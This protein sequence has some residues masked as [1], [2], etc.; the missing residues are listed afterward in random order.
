[1]L[2]SSTT[3]HFFLVLAAACNAVTSA[4]ESKVELPENH[5][6]ALRA[7]NLPMT[8]AL[9]PV[10]SLVDAPSRML[11]LATGTGPLHHPLKSFV[12]EHPDRPWAAEDQAKLAVQSGAGIVFDHPAAHIYF[13]DVC[14]YAAVTG[15]E[16]IDYILDD[17]DT[18]QEIYTG[19]CNTMTPTSTTGSSTTRVSLSEL[20]TDAMAKTAMPMADEMG[21]TLNPIT[22]GTYRATSITVA[23]D[24]TVT[25]QGGHSDI[26][27]FQ[28]GSTMIT[29]A[30]TKF[31]LL[32]PDGNTPT[33]DDPGPEPANILFAVHAAATTGA[34]SNI[35]GSIL[36]GAAITL[37]AESKATGI[38]LATAGATFGVASSVNEADIIDP[39]ATVSPVKTLIDA[40]Q[41]FDGAKFIAGESDYWNDQ[42]STNKVCV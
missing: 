16:A 3:S 37:G 12:A 24:T 26:F 13:G 30:N 17:S 5:H 25:L 14:A 22:K 33:A 21:N 40:A 28:S 1:M 23:S 9:T 6:P 2:F 18:V 39:D 36:A 34:A 41:C 19:G 15:L 10:E 35:E 8:T 27:L 4:K 7:G 11:D 20:L 29:G 32:N 38:L 31:V 42:D